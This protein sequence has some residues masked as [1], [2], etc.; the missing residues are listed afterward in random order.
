MK[1][2]K[3]IA[4]FALALVLVLNV[5]GCGASEAKPQNESDATETT[6]APDAVTD[7]NEQDL[8]L[9]AVFFQE[10][11]Y[12]KTVGEPYEYDDGSYSIQK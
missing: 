2:M 7:N 6:G 4:L 3:L 8:H 1:H 9:S 10:D 12:T 5:A 11:K